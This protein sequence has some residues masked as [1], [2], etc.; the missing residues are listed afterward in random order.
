[1]IEEINQLLQAKNFSSYN[2]EKVGEPR[3]KLKDEDYRALVERAK[4]HCHRGDVFQLVL[5]RRFEQKFK[6]DEFNVYRALRS[7]NPSTY[8]FYF[9]YG[10]FKI[11]GS[12]REAQLIIKDDKAEIKPIA[13]TF[14][15][16][17]N[18]ETDAQQPKDLSED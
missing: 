12:S 1:N 10:D 16:T 2:F 11:F 17:G 7:I 13:G 8:L 14:K 6:G 3:S 9:D 18:D 15:R 4:E 5:S